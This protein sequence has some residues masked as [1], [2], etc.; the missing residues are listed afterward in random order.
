MKCAA[1]EKCIFAFVKLINIALRLF[2]S[3]AAKVK[4]RR[5]RGTECEWR[6][7]EES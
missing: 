4:I 1:D 6:D 2:P 7:L 5:W 3:S